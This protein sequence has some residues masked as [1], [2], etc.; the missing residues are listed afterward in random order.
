MAKT[1]IKQRDEYIK[2]REAGKTYQEIADMY[3]V[4]RQCIYGIIH[5]DKTAARQKTDKYKAHRREYYAN[6][7]DKFLGAQKNWREKHP[8]YFKAYYRTHKTE[9]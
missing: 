4:S 1:S 3:G 7:K 8:N 2:L 9:K 5:R 6:N